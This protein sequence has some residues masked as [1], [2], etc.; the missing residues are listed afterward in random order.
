MYLHIELEESKSMRVL[1][2]EEDSKQIAAL[3]GKVELKVAMQCDS[4]VWLPICWFLWFD[5]FS[6]LCRV[7]RDKRYHRQFHW[8]SSCPETPYRVMEWAKIYSCVWRYETCR[9]ITPRVSSPALCNNR[10]FWR[11]NWVRNSISLV[12]IIS[13]SLIN[14]VLTRSS[15]E[16]NA[17]QY[18]GSRC[19]YERC[20]RQNHRSRSQD[21]VCSLLFHFTI[22]D[23][24]PGFLL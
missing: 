19:F 5:C 6:W 3:E 4:E 2:Y 10:H 22:Y 15:F 16:R 24:Q 18:P 21:S 1:L 12:P 11:S 7:W 13:V 8:L 20:R 14:Y 17:L 23:S 9:M